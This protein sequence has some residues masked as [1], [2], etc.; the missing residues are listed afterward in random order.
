MGEPEVEGERLLERQLRGGLEAAL[1]TPP[2]SILF[3]GFRNLT[4]VGGRIFRAD[5]KTVLDQ[6]CQQVG[7]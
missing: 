6:D 5:R 4:D 3:Q 1:D 2:D 7:R